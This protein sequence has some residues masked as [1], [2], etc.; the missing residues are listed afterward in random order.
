MDKAYVRTKEKKCGKPLVISILSGLLASLIAAAAALLIFSAA[1][2]RFDEPDKVSPAFGVAALLISAFAG[3]FV[4]ARAH[5][6]RG[7][8]SGALCG[9]IL[10]LIVAVASL[11]AGTKIS[12]VMF[13]ITAPVAV[14]TAALGGVAGAGGG[15]KTK[16]KKKTF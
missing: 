16:K 10:I 7:L 4:T 12:M 11:V 14:L 1:A 9:L 5:G 13:G 15:K 8:S 2:M 6:E 3:G